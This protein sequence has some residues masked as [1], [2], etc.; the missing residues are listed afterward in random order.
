M[1]D[2]RHTRND[3]IP[4]RS[5]FIGVLCGLLRDPD[6]RFNVECSSGVSIDDFFKVRQTKQTDV[7]LTETT[8]WDRRANWLNL[9]RF[10]RLVELKVQV[11][12]LFEVWP[13][14]KIE[15]LTLPRSSKILKEP[16]ICVHGMAIW[17]HAHCFDRSGGYCHSIFSL[18]IG[19]DPQNISAGAILNIYKLYIREV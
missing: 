12:M 17:T 19:F 16:E 8:V 3:L 9:Q 15:A 1:R 10:A 11:G 14:Y 18:R 4:L 13:R 2:R 5:R 6:A 7:L